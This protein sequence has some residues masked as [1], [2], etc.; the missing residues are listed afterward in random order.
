MC[1]SAFEELR[2]S[3]ACV[4]VLSPQQLQHVGE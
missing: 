2:E 3:R 1:L 4:L